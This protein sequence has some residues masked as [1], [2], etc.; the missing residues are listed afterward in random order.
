MSE[1]CKIRTASWRRLL[2]ISLG[3]L[4]ILAVGCSRSP[5][6]KYAQF[7]KVGNEQSAA[8]DY[9]RAILNYRNALQAQ[10]DKAD[11]HY[12][13]ALAYLAADRLPE[14]INELRR[15]TE[16]D[17]GHSKAQ[18]KLAEL[19]IRTRDRNIVTEAAERVQTVLANNPSDLDALY[20]YAAT[21]VQLGRPEQ[22][23][24]IL[25]RILE[26]SPA[27][28]KSILGL[29]QM[30][31]SKKD[32]EGAIKILTQFTQESPNSPGA[33]TAL[34]VVYAAT[35]NMANAEIHIQAALRVDP[36]DGSALSLLAA[37]QLQAGKKPEA[38]ATFRRLSQLAQ[39][40]FKLAYA[41]FLSR[42]HRPA[43]AA[44]ELE[45]I[46]KADPSNIEA[47]SRLVSGYA[48]LNRRDAAQKILSDALQKNPKDIEA[49]IQRSLLHL[50]EG[51]YTEAENDVNQI[52]RTDPGSVRARYIASRI[53]VARGDLI[54]AKAELSKVLE[55]EPTS[56]LARLDLARVHL[57]SNN[58]EAAQQTLSAA[59]ANQKQ[60]AAFAV[61]QG[62]VWI[63]QGNRV[64]ARKAVNAVLAVARIPEALIQDGIL[65]IADRDF[66]G[67]RTPLEEALK[68][69]PEDL[70]ALGALA[71][72]FPKG[73]EAPAMEK[74]RFYVDQKPGS[75]R[76]QLFWAQRLLEHGKKPEAKR[77]LLAAKVA[78]SKQFAPDVI[79]ARMD[80]DE[81]NLQVAR[82]RLRPL[83]AS[84]SSNLEAQVLLA[85]I[86]D[87]TSNP[88]GAID[89]YTR[90]LAVDSRNIMALNNLAF[91]LSR[92]DSRLDEALKHAQRAKELVPDD[93]HALDTLGW[94]Y[95]RKGLYQLAVRELELA[96]AAGSRPTIQFHLGLTYKRLGD[97]RKGDQLV[98]SAL[99]AQPD[100]IKT[101][102]LP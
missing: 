46:R 67:A 58:V 6:E 39:P 24:Q 42:D 96:L 72:S 28:L 5:Q 73:Q 3:L 84:G 23:E 29:A 86:E 94:I 8:Q 47:R 17:P 64:D 100:L 40:Q 26:Q 68:A 80:V 33:E 9:N 14:G 44:E 32:F 41:D 31:V 79:L 22:A 77:A 85:G 19:M 70:R 91:A 71:Q 66:A 16:L 27:D 25:N 13:L 18:L 11:G 20:A 93:S 89:L 59:P 62:W 60:T 1:L 50:N 82:D 54:K 36:N 2:E 4:V 51:Q 81:G 21:E 12:L 83:V 35:R 101:V 75:Y 99:T 97:S 87:A 37:T 98:A 43:D 45:R 90:V 102:A 63:A 30:K 49:L 95:Y 48:A 57:D 10:P 61:T 92:D 38:E 76:L 56:L 69:N 53:D 55:T 78:D 52:Y 15:A 34:A 7:I 74:V 65:R 88:A